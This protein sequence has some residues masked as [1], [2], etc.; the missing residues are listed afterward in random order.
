M[1]AISIDLKNDYKIMLKGQKIIE[2]NIKS[3]I[4]TENKTLFS[5]SKPVQDKQQVGAGSEH[6]SSL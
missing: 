5:G 3:L 2:A 1:I 6:F 4:F